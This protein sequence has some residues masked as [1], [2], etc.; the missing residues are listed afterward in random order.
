MLCC[1]LSLDDSKSADI[2]DNPLFCTADRQVFDCWNPQITVWLLT[3][4]SLSLFLP[5]LPTCRCM[6]D[7]LHSSRM[8]WDRDFQSYSNEKSRGASIRTNGGGGCQKICQQNPKFFSIA[9]T[10]WGSLHKF[11]N[12]KYIWRMIHFHEIRPRDTF[13]RLL[14]ISPRNFDH[15]L[16][17]LELPAMCFGQIAR[18]GR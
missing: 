8:L 6:L 12:F 14:T 3:N 4:V 16:M 11:R 9:S 10:P 18:R 1:E 17:I 5:R 15:N 2:S 13:I 7:L